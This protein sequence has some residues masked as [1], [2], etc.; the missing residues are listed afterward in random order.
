MVTI[1]P[2]A[3]QRL[4]EDLA[5]LSEGYRGLVPAEQNK[6]L[7]QIIEGFLG[8]HYETLREAARTHL[9]RLPTP[10]GKDDSWSW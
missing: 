5:R 1:M 7:D 8:E 10:P 2:T 4:H 6:H 9:S 3:R